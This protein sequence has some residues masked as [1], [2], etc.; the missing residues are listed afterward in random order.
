MRKLFG[1]SA[2][3]LFVTG[4]ALAQGAIGANYNEHFEDVDYRDL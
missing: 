1:L 3:L 4:P 2:A